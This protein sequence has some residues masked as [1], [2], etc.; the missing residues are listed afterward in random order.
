MVENGFVTC[1]N[2]QTRRVIV[3]NVIT[4]NVDLTFPG[5]DMVFIQVNSILTIG[6]SIIEPIS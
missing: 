2:Q 1:P 6:N 5:G 4:A 3:L